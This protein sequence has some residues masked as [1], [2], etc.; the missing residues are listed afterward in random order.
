ML[1]MM[2]ALERVFHIGGSVGWVHPECGVAGISDCYLGMVNRLIDLQTGAE[3]YVDDSLPDRPLDGFFVGR[4]YRILIVDDTG[5]NLRISL[6]IL[7]IEWKSIGCA[8]EL[9]GVRHRYG[10]RTTIW[11]YANGLVYATYNQ[12]LIILRTDIG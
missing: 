7:D 4:H 6:W 8:V 10:C 2:L 12:H 3:W 1:L 11:H 9:P 5:D